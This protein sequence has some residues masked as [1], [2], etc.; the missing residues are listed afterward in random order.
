MRLKG[1]LNQ[2]FVTFFLDKK[3]NQKNQDSKEI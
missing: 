1:T 3:S 2:S